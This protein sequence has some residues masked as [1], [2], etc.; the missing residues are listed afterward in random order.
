MHDAF[1]LYW[2][3]N[4]A[5]IDYLLVDYLIECAYSQIPA[6]KAQIDDVP[7]NNVHR[8]DLQAAMNAALPAGSWNE[9][10]KKETTLYKLS[11]RERYSRETKDGQRSIFDHF[12]N[13]CEENL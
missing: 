6:V 3:K 12:L 8:D 7:Y 13:N 10:I 1:E 9:V 4:D 2:E 11:W 5:A